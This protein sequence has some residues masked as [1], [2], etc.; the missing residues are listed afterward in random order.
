MDKEYAQELAHE[1]LKSVGRYCP[2]VAVNTAIAFIPT[3]RNEESNMVRVLEPKTGMPK[4]DRSEVADM[5]NRVLADQH[6][7]Y[8]KLRNYHW[9]LAGE[10]FV[11]V[12]RFLEELYNA[13]AEEIDLVAERLP[14]IGFPALGSMQEFLAL[15]S[16][17]EES[18]KK[19]NQR[20][21]ILALAD[22]YEDC[23]TTLR[24][25]I[26]KIDEDCDD[27]VTVD[28]LTDL[29]KSH[30]KNAWMLRRYAS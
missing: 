11:E 27:P 12:H 6:V 26:S 14:Q 2:Y 20:D 13:L 8:I 15:A 16:L 21:A 1:L 28:L 23:A 9:N 19:K 10:S 5:L 25:M 29:L 30:E 7:L 18:G 4:K 17:K 24:E 3:V 22:D